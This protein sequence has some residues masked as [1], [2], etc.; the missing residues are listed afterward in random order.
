MWYAFAPGFGAAIRSTKSKLKASFEPPAAD[1]IKINSVTYEI[2]SSR[3]APECYAFVKR[4]GFKREQELRLFIP[5][6]YEYDQGGG[7][8]EP[9]YSGKAVPVD[10]NSLM[11]EVWV[12]PNSPDWFVGVVTVELEKYGFGGIP[13]KRRS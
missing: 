7:I 12:P 10:L 11:N 13:V 1:K 5:Y 4:R 2:D 8:K 9:T 6:E 3:G